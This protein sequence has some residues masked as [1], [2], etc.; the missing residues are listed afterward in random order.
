[1]KSNA[2]DQLRGMRLRLRLTAREVDQ[3]SR[4]IAAAEANDQY[5]VS[6]AR[7][8][9][10]ENG[11]STPSVYKLF[12][13]SAIYGVSISRL[14]A[15]YVNLAESG[16]HRSA[17]SHT[18]LICAEEDA[19]GASI[20]FPI[21]FSQRFEN[22]ETQVLSRLVDTWGEVPV[23]LLQRLNLRESLWG[24]VGLD[25]YTM[26]PL[27]R[28]GSLVQIEPCSRVAPRATFRSEFERPIYFIELRDGY[29]CS[30]CE[31]QPGRVLCIPHP[32]SPV[33]IRSFACPQQAEIVGQ[34]T[35][36]AARLVDRPPAAMNTAGPRAAAGT[37]DDTA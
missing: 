18:Q 14:L 16:R 35:A 25:D 31:F 4:R 24:F 12:S 26:Y 1:M 37:R 29:V 5:V 27:L 15:L 10:I 23:G 20:E 6:H 11:E 2:G 21:R 3:A 19:A 7:L 8:I 17:P 22:T 32:L 34:V 36:V 13:L 33:P 28:P 30:W 9:Q